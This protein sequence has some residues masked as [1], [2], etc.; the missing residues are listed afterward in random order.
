MKSTGKSFRSTAKRKHLIFRLKITKSSA[1]LK[2]LLSKRRWS[3]TIHSI[4]IIILPAIIPPLC[5]AESSADFC[6]QSVR[7]TM[8][9]MKNYA[10]MWTVSFVPKSHKRRRHL[11]SVPSKAIM[12]TAMNGVCKRGCTYDLY[13][14]RL[15]WIQSYS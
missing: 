11:V 1:V 8:I 3:L 12:K 2:M 14:I 6:M 10:V 4:Q 15:F 7:A 13:W 5:S 9:V